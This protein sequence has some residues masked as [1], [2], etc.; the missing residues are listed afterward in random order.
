MVAE[1]WVSCNCWF[2]LLL[3]L[4]FTASV[5][6]FAHALLRTNLLTKCR[7]ER[8]CSNR[9]ALHP[10]KQSTLPV[11]AC[12]IQTLAR[13]HHAAQTWPENHLMH[14]VECS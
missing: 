2:C 10:L 12:H 3:L 7:C 13:R 4:Q 9:A 6:S 1:D 5:L 11:E 14:A 8:A